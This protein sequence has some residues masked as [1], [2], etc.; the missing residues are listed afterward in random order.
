LK[1]SKPTIYRTL[2]LLERLRLVKRFDV[3][4]NCFYYESVLHKAD[5]GHLICE[6]CGKIFDF[7]VGDVDTLKSAIVKKKSFTPGY[8]SIRVFGLCQSCERAR[9]G[10]AA[11]AGETKH[12]K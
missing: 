10:Q 4:K 6:G 3:R 1:V 9:S 7:S 5:H 12:V 2:K 11:K 8:L